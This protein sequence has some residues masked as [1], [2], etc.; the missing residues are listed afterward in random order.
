MVEMMEKKK[1]LLVSISVG[2]FLVIVIGAS[3]LVFSPRNP[4]PAA[5][6][7]PAPAVK[8]IPAGDPAG[9]IELVKNSL[10][11][12]KTPD[13]GPQDN[14]V[15]V[16]GENPDAAVTVDP[17]GS[18]GGNRLVVDVRRPTAAAVPEAPAPAPAPK[19]AATPARQSPAPAPKA[20]APKPAAP[21]VA[22]P[23]A[24]AP[25]TPENF[26]VQTGSFSTVAR[27]EAAKDTLA[28][29]GITSLIENRNVEGKDFFRVRV[30]PYTSQNE[31]DYW[32]KLIK[33]FNGFEGSIVLKAPATL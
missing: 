3:I 4:S 21:K 7:N 15:Y 2:V 26:W 32:Q 14:I 33:E 10:N 17:A 27:A 30:G 12:Q 20:A 16:Y 22:A 13:G 19:P 1:L 8:P 6:A 23:K 25:K 18:G 9:P 24:A 29:K 31:A 28:S 11:P 5:V